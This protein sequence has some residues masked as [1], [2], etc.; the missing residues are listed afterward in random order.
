MYDIPLGSL[1]AGGADRGPCGGDQGQEAA[2]DQHQ[3]SRRR[4]ADE[5]PPRRP[6][7]GAEQEDGHPLLLAAEHKAQEEAYQLQHVPGIVSPVLTDQFHRLCRGE[8]LLSPAI[9]R[10]VLAPAPR[11]PLPQAGP[12]Q[13][14]GPESGPLHHRLQGLGLAVK[15]RLGYCE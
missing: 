3:D 9:T 14:G 5:C 6:G 4:A 15:V 13:A 11:G 8:Q 1:A 12:L 2:A 7:P 10:L